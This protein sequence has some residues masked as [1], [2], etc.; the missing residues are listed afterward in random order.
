MKNTFANSMYLSAVTS[1][2]NWQDKLLEI[3]DSAKESVKIY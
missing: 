2:C 1:I 3:I